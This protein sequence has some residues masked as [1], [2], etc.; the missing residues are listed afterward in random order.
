MKLCLLSKRFFCKKGLKKAKKGPKSSKILLKMK[1]SV[2][3]VIC[4]FL[5]FF[6]LF[7]PTQ[8][9]EFF[10]EYFCFFLSKFTQNSVFFEFFWATKLLFKHENSNFEQLLLQKKFCCSF[11]SN[12][13]YKRSFLLK[14]WVKFASF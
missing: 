4:Y 2:L 13:C 11:V 1:N 7:W 10:F 14:F 9:T 3:W 6:G 8:Q 5:P 12:C